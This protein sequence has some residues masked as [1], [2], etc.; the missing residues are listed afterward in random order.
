[1]HKEQQQCFRILL[2]CLPKAV[3]VSTRAVA[4]YK[5]LRAGEI[6][7]IEGSGIKN[8][9][10]LYSQRREITATPTPAVE[11]L[12]SLS[13]PVYGLPELIRDLSSAGINSIYPPDVHLPIDC[14]AR[15]KPGMHCSYRLVADMLMLKNILTNPHKKALSVLPYVALVQEK[16][17]R[18]RSILS[19]VT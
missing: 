4:C 15:W 9:P 6:S 2:T 3:F 11:P 7:D 17:G 1:M 10:S 8:G 14:L 16:N 5:P 12:L 19:G 18:L 13:H